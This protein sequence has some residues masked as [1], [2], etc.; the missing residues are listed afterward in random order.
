MLDTSAIGSSAERAVVVSAEHSAIRWGS[1]GV[2]VFAT[3]MM[4]ALMEGAAV[5]A[6]ASF[7]PEGQGTVGTHLDVAHLAA[8]PM[9]MRVT[10]RAEL[11]AL[12]GRKLTFRVE[13]YDEVGKI[14]EGTHERFLIDVPRFMAKAQQRGRPA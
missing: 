14:G 1:G 3:P 11:I 7:L 12:D 13:A 5:A 10:A 6:V 2:D 8:T 4:I 9:G